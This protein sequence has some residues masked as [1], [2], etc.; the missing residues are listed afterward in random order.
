[1]LG[2]EEDMQRWTVRVGYRETAETRGRRIKAET[3]NPLRKSPSDKTA[4][5]TGEVEAE[6]GEGQVAFSK[7]KGKT[8][9]F[10]EMKA[11][12]ERNLRVLSLNAWWYL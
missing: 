3:H 7:Q 11:K 5:W 1:M 6:E 2:I 12:E 9:C 10:H 4:T 8:W